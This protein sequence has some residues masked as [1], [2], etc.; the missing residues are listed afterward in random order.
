[1]NI[2]LIHP[3][4]TVS[5]VSPGQTEPLGLAYLAGFIRNDYNVE[6]LD[7]FALGIDNRVKRGN[8]YRIGISD[9]KEIVDIIKQKKP[10]LVGITSNFTSYAEDALEVAKIVKSNFKNIVLVLGGAH[11]SMDAENIL[12]NNVFIDIVVRGEGEVTFKLL[13]DNIKE[14]KSFESLDGLTYR[15]K[16]NAIISNPSRKMIKD[17]NVL[18]YPARDLLDIEIY[19]KL[20]KQT[21]AFAKNTPLLSIMTSRGCPYNCIFC[22]TKVVWERLWRPRTPE[23]VV[24]EIESLIK[25]YHIREVAI[26]DDQFIVD[27]KRVEKICDLIIARKLNITISIPSGVS[28]WLLDE[29]LLRKMKKAGF[30]LLS[31]SIETGNEKTLKF[32]NKKVDLKKILQVIKTCHK[33][34]FW[35]MSNFI[36]GFP[37]ETKEDIE[38]TISYAYRCGVDYAVFLIA[39]PYAGAELYEIYAREGLLHKAGVETQTNSII[40]A[41]YDSKYFTA[42]QIQE[43][44]DKAAKEFLLKRFIS[45]LHPIVF[46]RTIFPKL[47]LTKGGL[48]Y[49]LKIVITILTNFRTIHYHSRLF[50]KDK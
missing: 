24:D 44:R 28:G 35:V 4:I 21:F 25:N 13:L 7:L 43:M 9:E 37:Y 29:N 33:L 8:K 39:Q 16:N 2:V 40:S 32:I 14:N 19:K 12:E 46:F 38:E 17:I 34:G 47:F 11:A 30:Y 45:Y 27:K 1:M 10:D 6:I 42:Q 23:N 26:Y 20:S 22:S 36:I 41:N 18:P 31:L 48:R 50:S 3:F 15:D 49:A 5:N